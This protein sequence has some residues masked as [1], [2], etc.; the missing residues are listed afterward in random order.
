[1]YFHSPRVLQTRFFERKTRNFTLIELLVVIA[2]IAILAGMLL[3][4]LQRARAVAKRTA[5]LNNHKQIALSRSQ[6]TL[7]N[8]DYIP[9]YCEISG[10]SGAKW[11]DLLLPYAKTGV[12]WICPGSRDATGYDSSKMSS[13]FIA[14]NNVEFYAHQ[15]IGINATGGWAGSSGKAFGL[16]YYKEAR[17]KYPSFLIYSGD[18]TSKQ[19]DYYGAMANTS[20]GKPINCFLYPENKNSYYSHHGKGEYS[21]MM[22]GGNAT[23]LSN[24]KMRY[25]C[26]LVQNGSTAEDT[27]YLRADIF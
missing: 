1:M 20:G 26:S 21:V 23:H 11:T 5:C 16:T 6:Y 15:N 12:I 14:G 10:G 3:P 27:K 19:T 18:T 24:S 4:A 8:N 7:D 17:I 13:S 2:I 25:L 9:P 22:L